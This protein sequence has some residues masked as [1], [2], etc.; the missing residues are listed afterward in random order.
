MALVALPAAANDV[1]YR[2]HVMAA[3]GG[4][5]QA[6]AEILRQ[7]VPHQAH[8]GLHAESLANLAAIA[9]S[10]FPAGSEGGDTL[11][12]TWQR[13]DDFAAKLQDFEEAAAG[14]SAAVAAEDRVGPAFQRLGQSCKNC[15]DDYRAK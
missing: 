9:G 10:L 4:H 7:R 8:A 15:H 11:P 3:V 2:Q 12:A 13:P 1:D 6:S 5:M 14:F